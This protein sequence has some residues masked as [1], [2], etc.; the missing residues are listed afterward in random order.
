MRPLLALLLALTVGVAFAACGESPVGTGTG[1]SLV[2]AGGPPAHAAPQ[3][4]RIVTVDANPDNGW[5]YNPDPGNATPTEFSFDEAVLGAGSIHGL[6][7]PSDPA[8][9]FILVYAPDS[10]VS[11]SDFGGFSIDFLIDDAGTNYDVDQFYVNVY[12][13][14]DPSH[15]VYYDCRFDY[16]ASSG[17]TT[18]WTTLGLDGST[19]KSAGAGSGCP[20][21][22]DGMP[23]GSVITFL[24]VNIGD[25][26]AS[27]AGIGGY[28]DNALWTVG[29]ATTTFDFEPSCKGGGWQTLS[30]PDG[31]T[32]KNQGACRKYQ[33]TGK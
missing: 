32:F 7:L 19:V 27:D 10:P 11:I 24:A 3:A 33:K 8:A 29:G 2:P 9:K 21:S 30:R 12:T 4:H 1:G 23:A 6:P 28:F 25:T 31:S 16:I 22:L 17:S 15:D 26:S 20:S 14:T 18:D 13:L 5:V